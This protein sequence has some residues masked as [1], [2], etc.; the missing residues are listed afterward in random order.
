MT[1]TD[2]GPLVAMLDR[3]DQ[4]HAGCVSAA[5]QCP[6]TRLLTTWPCF[7]EAM[8]LLGS[9]GGMTYQSRLWRLI[10]EGRLQLHALSD[11]EILRCERLMKK[12]D[13]VPMDLADASIVAVAETLGIHRVFTVDSGFHIFRLIDGR[14]LELFP[15]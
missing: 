2:T 15:V 1:L 9:T 14:S 7:T 13:N 6:D 8:Y 5:R 10:R 3:S 12:Y 11:E 4:H